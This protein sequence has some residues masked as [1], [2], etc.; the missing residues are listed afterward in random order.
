MKNQFKIILSYK[1]SKSLSEYHSVLFHVIISN[2][3]LLKKIEYEEIKFKF[4]H[5]PHQSHII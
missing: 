5:Q 2:R 1:L 4:T 3:E